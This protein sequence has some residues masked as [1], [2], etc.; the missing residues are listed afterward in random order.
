MVKMLT[1]RM[2][3]GNKKI[4]FFVRRKIGLDTAVPK[5]PSVYDPNPLPIAAAAGRPPHHI[6]RMLGPAREPSDGPRRGQPRLA[7]VF[8][9][10]GL[11]VTSGDFGRLGEAPSR[12]E[13][14]GG[15]TKRFVEGG[16]SLEQLHREI[17]LSQTYRQ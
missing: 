2:D 3:G 17:V 12:P 10:R 14:L 6:G 16:W 15:L 4:N 1:H 9:G 7:A 5:G 13:L 11:V 8:F